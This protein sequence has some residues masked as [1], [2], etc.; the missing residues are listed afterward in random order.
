MIR[1]LILAATLLAAGTAH[2]QGASPTGG[3]QAQCN[4][5]GQPVQL[6]LQY[7][8][9]GGGGIVWGSGPNPEIKGVIADG[10]RTIYW[11]GQ[12]SGAQGTLALEGENNFLRFY[13]ANVYNRETVLRIDQTGP[14]TFT[15]TDQFQNYPGSHPCQIVETW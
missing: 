14:S 9:I 6:M 10:S 3:F 15:L 2:A 5:M 8:A 4:I 13:D 1:Q 12:M 7:E 11:Q